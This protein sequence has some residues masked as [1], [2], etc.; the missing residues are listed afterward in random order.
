MELIQEE[1]AQGVCRGDQSEGVPTSE[2]HALYM[3]GESG[4]GGARDEWRRRGGF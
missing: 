3:Q 1:G 4:E 2:R